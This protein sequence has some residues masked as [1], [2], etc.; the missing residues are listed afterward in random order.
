MR[1]GES[2]NEYVL[3]TPFTTAGGGQCQWAF[4]RRGGR[5][6]FIKQFLKPTYPVL[7]GPGSE[8]SR[9]VKRK[10][11]DEFAARHTRIRK[12]LE[13]LSA[14]GGN[15]VVAQDFFLHDAHYYK[16]TAK[17]EVGADN[18][19]HVAR[20]PLADKTLLLIAVTSSLDILH[21]NGL[22]HGDLK[23]PNIL[24]ED[25]DGRI[26]VKLID[27]DDCYEAGDP[28]A[29]E[30]LV[31]DLYY[32]APEVVDYIVGVGP[33]ERLTQKSDVYALGLTF[34]EYVTGSRL[35]LAEGIR[36]PS[37]LLRDGGRI[38]LRPGPDTG[39]LIALIESMLLADPAQRPDCPTIRTTLQRIRHGRR[40]A[41]PV[42]GTP[43]T[44]TPPV[45]RGKLLDTVKGGGSGTG[46]AG[47]DGPPTLKGS[48]IDRTAAG[49]T[50]PGIPPAAGLRGRLIRPRDPD[51]RK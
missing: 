45:P 8:K 37:E 44:A 33:A 5:D 40:G 51:E 41:D 32:H 15:L 43:A 6:Y 3:T 28:P 25:T 50:S 14:T 19:A 42:S 13:P 4:A 20:L 12:K 17:V 46:A 30:E 22:V 16:V 49:E 39:E 7:G 18:P 31:G 26:G 24:V 36:Y 11:C 38:E 1:P 2:I 23:P 21:R 29:A 35:H 47:P 48:L 27:F 9:A 34:L 10:R